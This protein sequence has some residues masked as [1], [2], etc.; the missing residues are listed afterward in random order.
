MQNEKDHIISLPIYLNM[1]SIVFFC[2]S[3]FC[4]LICRLWLQYVDRA[5]DSNIN[6]LLKQILRYSTW[7]NPAMAVTMITLG[8]LKKVA[9]IL[10]FQIFTS[11][12]LALMVSIS[13][14]KFRSSSEKYITGPILTRVK[15]NVL[16]I[17]MCYVSRCVYDLVKVASQSWFANMR[18][19]EANTHPN[20]YYYSLFLFSLIMV[21]EYLPILMFTLNLNFVFSTSMTY[22]PTREKYSVSQGTVLGDPGKEDGQMFQSVLKLPTT[23]GV[24]VSLLTFEHE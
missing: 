5:L 10:A 22:T 23:G 4:I 16:A 20:R 17:C 12:C 8:L 2:V 18:Q 24:K 13:G 6:L 1:S 3:Q 7:I 9:V 15:L 14:M 19:T 21:V 11:V